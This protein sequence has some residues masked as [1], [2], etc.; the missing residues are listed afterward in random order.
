M[1]DS[2]RPFIT[3]HVLDTVAGKPGPGIA[4]RLRLL[5]PFPS[6]PDAPAA[7]SPETFVW[8]ATTN[9]DGRVTGWEPSPCSSSAAERTE[10]ND[11]VA[12]LKK[13][14]TEEKR[15]EE[16][17]QML[18]SLTFETEKY[19]GKG[20]TFWPEVELRFAAKKEGEEHYHVPLLLGPWSYTTYRGS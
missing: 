7:Q 12:Q 18:F 3:C 17:E 8:S 14:P 9:S 13:Q 2:S 6:S 16:E 4:V 15:E 10:L 19:Y 1:P 11:V 20:K 5:S